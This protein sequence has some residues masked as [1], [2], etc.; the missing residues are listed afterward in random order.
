MRRICR[1]GLLLLAAC[2]A[3]VP[4]VRAEPVV[5]AA[6]D[7][8]IARFEA[9]R[10][11]LGSAFAGVDIAAY[12]DALTLRRFASRHW[13]GT[14]ALAVLTPGAGE[15][16]CARYAAFVRIPPRQGSVALAFCPEFL[17]AGTPD[18]RALTVLHEMVHVVAGA[19]ECRAMAF[20]ARVEVLA[21]GRFTDVGRYWRANGCDA[22]PFSLPE[23]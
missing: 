14:V 19:D 13:G 7:L 2:L 23:F 16:A 17:G 22:S 1:I 15:A 8:A 12:R 4:A 20:A 5:E 18:L 21:T 10:P 9:A 6:F 3:T 11:A